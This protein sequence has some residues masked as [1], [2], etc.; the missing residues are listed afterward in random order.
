MI[1]SLRA[2]PGAPA[3]LR[4]APRTAGACSSSS[5]GPTRIP[6]GP[7]RA[8]FPKGPRERRALPARARAHRAGPR[9]VSREAEG[10]RQALR[11]RS[12]QAAARSRARE[13]QEDWLF[14]RNQEADT[15]ADGVVT[16]VGQ[17]GGRTVCIMANDYTV[18]AGLLGRED[19]AEDRAHPG[20]GA[21][22]LQRADALPGRRGRRAH[23]RADQDLPRPL[24][25]R[26]HLLQRGPALRRRA[27]GLHPLRPVAGG[28][29]VSARAHRSRDHGR[30]QGVALRRQPAHGRDGHRR[31]DDARGARRRAHA[32]HGL[33]LRRRARGLRRG[34]HRA[35]PSATSS[36][37]PGSFRERPAARDAAPSRS[38]AAPSRRSCPTTSASGST[39]TR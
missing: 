5:S 25:R 36:Y 27:P 10:G 23:L 39:C 20:E 8:A 6:P 13:F 32:L 33:G 21:Q 19:G 24:P 11:P 30:R 7:C 17:V 12:P 37:M 18:K 2:S 26:P 34:R 9:Q 22:R 16:G 38:P 29:R 28:L 1:A 35:R 14:A 4:R 31:E 15:P 3:M